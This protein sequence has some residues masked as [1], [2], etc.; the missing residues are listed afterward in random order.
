ME[1]DED[2]YTDWRLWGWLGHSGSW[3]RCKHSDQ[4]NL[5]IDGKANIG[6]VVGT[7]ATRK[8]GKG[9]DLV[10]DIEGMKMHAEFDVIEV[11]D[12]G[13]SYPAL[14]G[15]GW[16]SDSMEIINFKKWVMTFEN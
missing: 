11:V 12:D 13:G 16:A 15:I 1:Q 3:I 4:A 9:S 8:S 7:A 6:M 2:K 10:F 14:L 5:E